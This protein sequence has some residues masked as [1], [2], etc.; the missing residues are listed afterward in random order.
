MNNWDQKKEIQLNEWKYV[1]EVY[2]QLHEKQK[3][4]YKKKV[5]YLII[6]T[7]IISSTVTILSSIATATENNFLLN[8]IS[9]ILSGT[10][11]CFTLYA[12]NDAPDQKIIRHSESAKGYREIVLKIESHLAIDIESRINGNEFIKDISLKMLDLE[13]G[14]ES[15]PIITKTEFLKLNNITCD[16]KKVGLDKKKDNQDLESDEKKDNPDTISGLSNNQNKKFE[17]FFRKFPSFNQNM[18]EF[19]LNRLNK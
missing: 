19:Q 14:S 2:N 1:C 16:N 9:A 12:K 18:I 10:A 8:V 7:I 5:N 3:E 15:I 17:L 11:A 6:P 4:Y 13:T